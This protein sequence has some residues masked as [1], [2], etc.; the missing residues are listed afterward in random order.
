MTGVLGNLGQVASLVLL[1]LGVAAMYAAA[2]LLWR[3]QG[4]MRRRNRA[5]WLL[6]LAGFVVI[7]IGT[8]G[9]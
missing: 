8:V 7:V 9:L 1:V 4:S 5:P 2:F 6:L 3:P